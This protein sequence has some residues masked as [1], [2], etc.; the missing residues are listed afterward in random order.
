MPYEQSVRSLSEMNSKCAISCS[1][2]E[3]LATLYKV[4]LTEQMVKLN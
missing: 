2:F 3:N 4:F 1:M